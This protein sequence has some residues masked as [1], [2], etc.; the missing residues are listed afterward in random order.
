MTTS[1][2]ITLSGSTALDPQAGKVGRPRKSG[3]AS[4]SIQ[5]GMKASAVQRALADHL[6]TK[7][8]ALV[9]YP[10]EST[11]DTLTFVVP[12]SDKDT[13]LCYL[14]TEISLEVETPVLEASPA[15][16]ETEAVASEDS[17]VVFLTE[18]EPE[19][20]ASMSAAETAASEG[21]PV[22]TNWIGTME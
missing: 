8:S 7:A 17:A 10:R 16:L 9:P 22:S 15:L 5:P 6:G 14:A 20:E 21:E 13:R 1:I 12:G 3:R 2:V 4:V 18:D 11:A 19:P